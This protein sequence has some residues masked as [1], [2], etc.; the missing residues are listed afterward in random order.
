[1]SEIITIDWDWTPIHAAK[2]RVLRLLK[3]HD[4]AWWV[5]EIM[6]VRYRRSAG[7]LGTHVVLNLRGNPNGKQKMYIRA[8]MGDDMRRW[9][10]NID[11]LDSKLTPVDYGSGIVFDVKEGREAG[12]W[13]RMQVT[14]A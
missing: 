9:C 11:L 7:G 2:A 1:M 8:A 5:R 13:V 12:P 6:N 3:E 4:L 10:W 14:K